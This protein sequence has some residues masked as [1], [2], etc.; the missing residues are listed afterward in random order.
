MLS[1]FKK[2]KIKHE[3]V[4]L[5]IAPDHVTFAQIQYDNA[6]IPIGVVSATEL[7][8]DIK[9]LP[10]LLTNIVSKNSFQNFDCNIVL[11]PDYY[12][13]L[14]VDKPQVPEDEYKQA[15]RW[16]IKGMVNIPVEDLAIDFFNPSASINEHSKKLY[17]IAS[18]MSFLKTMVDAARKAFLNPVT[19]DIQEFAL[20][21]L[22]SYIGKNDET[23]ACLHLLEKKSIFFIFNKNE[24]HLV[25]HIAYG[26]SK[27]MGDEM[28]YDV[29][30]EIKHTLDYYLHQ[31]NKPPPEKV[32]IPSM[33]NYCITALG[34]L[35]TALG[36]EA[37]CLTVDELSIF[38]HVPPEQ[39]NPSCY[40]ALGGG[41]RGENKAP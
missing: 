26:V 31:L 19:I 41:L 5:D 16:Q 38:N 36:L 20:R 25:R 17:V 10:D 40:I 11:H 37:K 9:E 2:E 8:S 21:N 35:K 13:L 12:N 22:L 1:L 6:R 3:S 34:K 32:F 28:S 33:N 4:T 24:I 15:L 7:Y 18:K 23:V 30:M 27:F 39:L 29:V 14:L